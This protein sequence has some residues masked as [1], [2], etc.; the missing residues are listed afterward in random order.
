VNHSAQ[1]V[2]ALAQQLRGERAIV[3]VIPWNQVDGME[4][5]RPPLETSIEFVR[6]LKS[7]GVFATIRRSA[8]QDVDGG[9]GQLRSRTQ[10]LGAV[11]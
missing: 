3:N 11:S 9:C 1:D 2:A 4:Y 6:A 5:R 10:A 8:G 7:D